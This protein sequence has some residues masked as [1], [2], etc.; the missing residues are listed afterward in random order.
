[1]LQATLEVRAL[2]TP[3]QLAKAAEARQRHR[4]RTQQWRQRHQGQ[5]APQ[6]G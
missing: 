6:G 5:P 4:E 1:M 3:E 2:L